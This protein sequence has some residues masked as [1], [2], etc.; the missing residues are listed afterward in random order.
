[1]ESTG[2]RRTGGIW[3][4]REEARKSWEHVTSDEIIYFVQADRRNLKGSHP[5]AEKYLK[6]EL[7]LELHFTAHIRD[8]R[9]THFQVIVE[10]VNKLL[11][12]A[13]RAG[14][15]NGNNR[16]IGWDHSMFVHRP[17]FIELPKGIVP[18]G[19]PSE[20]RLKGVELSCHCGWKQAAPIL[21]SAVPLLED[22]EANVPLLSLRKNSLG[23]EV[24]QAP[25][26][27]VKTRSKT[28]NEIP[29]QHGNYLRNQTDIHAKD[30]DTFFK[31]CVFPD[32]RDVWE[33]KPSVDLTIQSVKVILRPAGFHLHLLHNIA[34]GD[35]HNVNS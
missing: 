11:P 22:Q 17:E 19:V 4:L 1:V 5:F 16:A 21:V 20:V 28:A 30:V 18:V 15:R 35:R 14:Q 34:L 24:S 10:V 12:R 26:Q 2:Q 8:Q 23:V 27:L 6:G 13:R 25:R 7:W 31:L 33:R 32:H 9:E 3:E 29:K